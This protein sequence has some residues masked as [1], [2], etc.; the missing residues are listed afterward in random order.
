MREPNDRE[1]S[2][3]L[4]VLAIFVGITASFWVEEWREER[5][6]TETF[7]RILGEVYYNLIFDDAGFVANATNNNPALQSPV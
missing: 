2:L 7:H 6:D 5:Q 1:K 3:L 4:E